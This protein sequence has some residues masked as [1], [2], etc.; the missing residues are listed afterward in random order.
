MGVKLTTPVGVVKFPHITQT[1]ENG[2]YGL[3]LSLDMKEEAVK[4]FLDD[5]NAAVKESKYPD[6]DKLIKK[7]KSRDEAGNLVENGNIL[8]N[9]S[10]KYDIS[11]FDAKKNKIKGPVNLGW[12]SK[13][14]VAFTLSEFDMKGKKGLTKY[15][16]AIQIIE[17]KAGVS[18]EGCGF[19]EEE[20]Y[21]QSDDQIKEGEDVPWEE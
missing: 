19:K 10:S 7:D 17:L 3:G 9:F 8:L 4:L 16:R 6:Y 20:G 21:A 13:V 12:G 2:K 15:V 5:L 11:C 18:A 1:D 14:R